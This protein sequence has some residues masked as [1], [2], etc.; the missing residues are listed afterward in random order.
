MRLT[1]EQIE[2]AVKLDY[3]SI[4]EIKKRD[5]VRDPIAGI[6]VPLIGGNLI[7]QDLRERVGDPHAVG[8]ILDAQE[9]A[10]AGASGDN[11]DHCALAIVGVV[12]EGKDYRVDFDG[13]GSMGAR[14]FRSN[15]QMIVVGP[16]ST[17]A[18]VCFGRHDAMRVVGAFFTI[19]E[20]SRAQEE[21]NK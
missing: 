8:V 4:D 7:L 18:S 6:M 11:I 10:G 17:C 16:G 20:Y 12:D 15:I 1:Q 9:V 19:R 5:V 14:W 13:G 21:M 3:V 2:R